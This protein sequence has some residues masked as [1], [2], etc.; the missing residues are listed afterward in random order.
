MPA[1]PTFIERCTTTALDFSSLERHT[2]TALYGGQHAICMPAL[3][4][5]LTSP[6]SPVQ[7]AG[8]LRIAMTA[9]HIPLPN[10]QTDQGAQGMRFMGY[11]AFEALVSYDLNSSS[12]P[13]TLI[14]GLATGWTIDAKDK[15]RWT[16]TLRP[17]VKFHDGSAFNTQAVVWNLDKILNQ[18]AEQFDPRQS[19]QGRTRIPSVASYKVI[20]DL[21]VEIVTREPDSLL[22]P[23]MARI[24]MSSPA[25]WAA[26]GKSWDAFLKKPAGTGPWKPQ[27]YTQRER[28]VLVR[29]ADYWD[30]NRVP[31]LDSIVLLPMPDA[32]ARVAA[33]RSGQVDWRELPP[34]DAMDTLKAAKFNIVSNVYPHVWPW[35]FSRA[36]G[37]PWNDIRIRKAANL[38]IGRD[39][40]K[41]LLGA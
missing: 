2:C 32:S 12:K 10:G 24:V 11:T 31:K 4:A 5:L 22:P 7:A 34:P 39:G 33:L 37:S 13:V 3:G 18:Q 27:T 8:T 41:A 25:Q 9:A 40:M 16:F 19:A 36:E 1:K 23:G 26:A 20:N 14:S 17:G 30:K 21:A 28:A 6:T 35:H 38:A 29:N 15:T